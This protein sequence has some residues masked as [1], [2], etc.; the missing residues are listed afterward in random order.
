MRVRIVRALVALVLAA[1]PHGAVVGQSQPPRD[2][3]K[4]KGTWRLVAGQVAGREL[5]KATLERSISLVIEGDKLT[6]KVKGKENQPDRG[7]IRLDATKTPRTIDITDAE[8]EPGKEPS[9]VLGIYEVDGDTLKLCVSRPDMK[10]R[11]K[12]FKSSD[13]DTLYRVDKRQPEVPF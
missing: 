5:P 7:V 2:L 13:T 12:E 9:V 8:P 11:P 6:E 1:L 4:L 10:R 3:E